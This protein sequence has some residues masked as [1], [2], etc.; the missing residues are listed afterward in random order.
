MSL[1]VPLPLLAVNILG[2]EV[3]W[4]VVGAILFAALI[5]G[6]LVTFSKCY[7]RCPSNKV[8]V[9]W[10][11]GSGTKTAK[12]IHGGG[13]LVLPVFQDYDYLSLEPIQIEIPLRGALSFENIR[14]NVPSVFTVAIGTEPEVMQ[15]AAIRMLGLSRDEISRQTADLIFGQL[16]QVIAQMKIEDINRDR[17]GFLKNIQESLEPELRKIGLVLINV[18]IT[19]L[20]DDSGYI[21]AIGKKAASAAINKAEIDVAEQIKLGAIGVAQAQQLQAVQVAEA[22]K[23]REIGTKDAQRE[24]VVRVA[25][26]QREEQVGVE[27]ARFQQQASVKEA[28]RDMRIQLAEAN[29]RAIQGEN[30]AQAEVAASNAE[31][32]F[33]QAEAFQ[34]GETRK[35]EADAAVEEAAFRAQTKAALAQAEK[36]EA[37]QRARLEAVAKAEKAKA[38]V[39][40]EAVSERRRIEAQGEA[41]AIFAK[42]E[43]EAKGQYEGLSKKAEGLKE[44]VAACGGAQEAFQLLMLE[45][46][47]KLSETAA[48]AI[49]N[50]K[51]DKVIV[52]EGGKN[53]DGV[54]ST[55]GFLQNMART[56]PPMLQIMQDIGGVKMPE[57]FGKMVEPEVPPPVG[58]GASPKSLAETAAA[59]G[60]GSP[61]TGSG[62]KPGKSSGNQPKAS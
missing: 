52:W 13:E 9:K 28:E 30:N 46:L 34:R 61:G 16:R 17:E 62:S 22:E 4:P 51:F 36:V 39:D 24:R 49:S 42:L 40:A 37:E 45:R 47:D 48:Q 26:L 55:A 7:K 59:S 60:S 23:V 27:K 35:R 41:S 38:I 31:L 20:T 43:A 50:I 5:F 10:G 11:V 58:N 57:Y 33:K 8:L 29:A 53:G 3:S 15:N 1:A 6:S 19:D 18:N 14:V 32:A 56:L 12:T 54:G 25:E 2:T 21:E 44:I